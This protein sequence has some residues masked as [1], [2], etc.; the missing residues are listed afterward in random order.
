[1]IYPATLDITI[2]QNS[3]FRLLYRALQKQKTI[4]SFAVSTGSPVF[5]VPCHGLSAGDKV[6]VVPAGSTS[7][8]YP[9]ATPPTPPAKPC[10]L[11]LN[12]VYFVIASG[13]T[14]NAFTVSATSG[15]S[16]I[17]V[18]DQPLEAG[19]CIAQPVDLTGY[20]ADADLKGLIDDQQVATFT[21]ALETAADGLVS[22]S[23]T[24]STAGS[25]QMPCRLAPVCLAQLPPTQ[26]AQ[27]R[28]A[29]RHCPLVQP[30]RSYS[31]LHCQQ[32]HNLDSDRSVPPLP[33]KHDQMRY[34]SSG[35]PRKRTLHSANTSQPVVTLTGTT[36]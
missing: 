27:C 11:D 8:Q 14:T 18:A 28:S 17:T 9:S 7:A 6:V 10:G 3:T 29:L 13:L 21:C 34:C 22:I 19:M 32:Q 2:L 35:V 20:T 36:G 15:G 33:V 30:A 12:R 23:M 26:A 24:P 25:L 31:D 1:M 16:A 4:A 5:T